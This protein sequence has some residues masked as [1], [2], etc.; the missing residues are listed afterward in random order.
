MEQ[1][2]LFWMVKD[3]ARKPVYNEAVRA[4]LETMGW[5]VEGEEPAPARRG[6]KAKVEE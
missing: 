4:E 5:V 6:R 2:V 1:T 3:G